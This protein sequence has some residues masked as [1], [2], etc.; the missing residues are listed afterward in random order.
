V[1]KAL[2]RV[3][4]LRRFFVDVL[5]YLFPKS[6]SRGFSM[7]TSYLLIDVVS[8]KYAP[9]GTVL[10]EV[11]KVL[12]LIRGFIWGRNRIVSAIIR[13]RGHD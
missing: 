12:S 10:I 11:L 2:E 7:L 6:S 1:G 9:L 8:R 3:A 13:R 4:V 5:K